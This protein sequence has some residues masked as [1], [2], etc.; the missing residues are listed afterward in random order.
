M[1][2]L[3]FI[4]INNL[5][6]RKHKSEL[7]VYIPFTNEQPSL[8]RTVEQKVVFEIQQTASLF[9][10]IYHQAHSGL[11]SLL[12]SILRMFKTRTELTEALAILIS[13]MTYT[14]LP[15]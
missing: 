6:V 2:I 10:F 13:F 5:H 15:V 11:S 4:L 12:L 1:G 8:L 14:I 3:K 7:K 9:L